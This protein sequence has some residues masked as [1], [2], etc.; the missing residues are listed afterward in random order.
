MSRTVMI[1]GLLA[2]ATGLSACA[3]G[4][5]YYGP[6]PGHV[7]WCLRHHPGYDPNTNLFPGPDGRPHPCRGPGA[8]GPPQPPPPPPT[9]GA[10]PP[11]PPPPPAY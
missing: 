4:P 7:R 9:Y 10:P 5:A 11:P 8:Y 3:D 1:L 2:A 6:P